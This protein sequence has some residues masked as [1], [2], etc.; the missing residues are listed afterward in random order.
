MGVVLKEQPAEVLVMAIEKVH[1]GEAWFDRSTLASVLASFA[2]PQ[3]P[4][5]PYS[6]AARIATLT[7][8][9][10]EVITLV[11]QS[12]KNRAI[13]D[14]LFIR[15]ATVR[16]HLSS[17]FDKLGVSDRAELMLYAIRHGLAEPPG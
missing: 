12:L 3:H 17:I 15:E 16:H 14:R 13:A 5:E 7:K 9:E 8:R 2:D 11:A 10:R 4:Q 1:A 6:H